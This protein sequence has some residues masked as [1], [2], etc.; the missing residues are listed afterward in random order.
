MTPSRLLGVGHV[1]QVGQRV[2]AD[3]VGVVF[4]TDGGEELVRFTVEDVAQAVS[5]EADVDALQFRRVGDALNGGLLRLLVEQLAG[6]E[7]D[8]IE[9]IV[10]LVGEEQAVALGIDGDMIEAA[11]LAL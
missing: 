1:D 5:A 3:V 8:N 2:V 4:E 9:R 7:I 10:A 11:G 6:F